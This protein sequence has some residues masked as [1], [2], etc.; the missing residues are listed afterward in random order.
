M[1]PLYS[2]ARVLQL[3]SSGVD[4]SLVEMLLDVPGQSHVMV[5]RLSALVRG[6]HLQVT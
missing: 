6:E 5:D 3:N 4:A 1:K 2:G